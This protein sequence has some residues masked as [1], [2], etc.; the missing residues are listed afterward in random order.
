MKLTWTKKQPTQVGWYWHKCLSDE[1][2]VG[3]PLI[4]LIEDVFVLSDHCC[5]Q[6]WWAGPISEPLKPAFPGPK[7]STHRK[8]GPPPEPGAFYLACEGKTVVWSNPDRKVIIRVNPDGT[9]SETPYWQDTYD[10]AQKDPQKRY[11]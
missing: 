2:G 10:R 11:R 5:E 9:K 4:V 7:K 6:C 8:H 1:A 3:F